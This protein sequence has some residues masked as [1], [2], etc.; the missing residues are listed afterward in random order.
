MTGDFERAMRFVARWEGGLVDHP[1]D[2]GGRTN[3]GVTQK[4]YDAWRDRRHL[5][6]RDV[7]ELEDAEEHSIYSEEYWYPAGCDKLAWPLCLVHFDTAVNLGVQRARGLVAAA[8]G[9]VG[10]YL[11][12]RRAYYT[13]LA[14][15]RPKLAVFL[16]GWLNRVEAL[17]AEAV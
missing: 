4:T 15:V 14:Q 5:P 7:S 1:S 17:E 6:H 3:R 9:D 11:T 13:T 2:P 8:G 16:R 10:A 12:K